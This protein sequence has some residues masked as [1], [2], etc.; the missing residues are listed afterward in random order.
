MKPFLVKTIIIFVVVILVYKLTIGAEIKKFQNIVS[1]FSEKSQRND[2]KRKILL[3]MERGTKKDNYFSEDE[4]Q[5]ISKFLKKIFKE[6][7]LI[8]V[9]K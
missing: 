2:L 8:D 3:E 1:N 7:E 4:R 5:I 9:K 6:L